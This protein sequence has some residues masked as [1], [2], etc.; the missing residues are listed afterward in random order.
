MSNQA[1]IYVEVRVRGSMEDLWRLT[2]EPAL[3]R[4]WDLRFSEIRYL[5][6][7][8]PAQPI[9]IEAPAPA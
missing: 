5:P 1:G 4:R 3:H 8:D 9:Q 6:R 7:R 2:Q